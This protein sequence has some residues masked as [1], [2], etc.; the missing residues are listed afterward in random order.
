MRDATG[1][2]GRTRTR[3]A[4][5]PI[6]ARTQDHLRRTTPTRRPSGSGTELPSELIDQQPRTTVVE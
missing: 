4:G 2:F 1:L 5:F 6:R 3:E